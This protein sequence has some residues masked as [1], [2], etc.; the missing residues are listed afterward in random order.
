M[1][2]SMS[3]D[4]GDP[5]EE[6]MLQLVKAVRSIGRGD[7]YEPTGLE[8]LSMAITGEGSIGQNSLS[9]AIRDGLHEIAE[10]IREGH[11]G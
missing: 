6:L 4:D 11:E 3:S 2:F 1:N 9:D 7:Q 5:Y 10:A 8:L